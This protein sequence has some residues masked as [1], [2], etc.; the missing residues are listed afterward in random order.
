[1]AT[2]TYQCDKCNQK[3]DL[4]EKVGKLDHVGKCTITKSCGGSLYKLKR[5]VNNIRTNVAFGSTPQTYLKRNI[6]NGYRQTVPSKIWKIEHELGKSVVIIIFGEDG[7]VVNSSQYEINNDGN[8]ATITFTSSINGYAHVLS[9]VNTP[10][11]NFDSERN[12]A[13]FKLSTNHILTFAIPNYIT[14]FDSGAGASS[15]SFNP[16]LNICSA[17]IKIE[18]EVIRP[19]SAPIYCYEDLKEIDSEYVGAWYNWDK[20]L[21]RNRKQY[22]LRYLNLKH[23]R[24]L[25]PNY[26]TESDLVNGTQMKITKISYDGINYFNIPD[27]GLLVLLSNPPYKYSDKVLDKFVDCGEIVG[28]SNELYTFLHEELYTYIDV[29]ETTFPIITKSKH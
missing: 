5:N 11:I 13:T 23:L 8:I 10:I 29:V 26:S 3:I 17:P 9:R 20:I 2:I 6:F 28:T 12:D 4:L 15:T 25:T 27:K 16:P 19:N 22:C 1:M 21:I 14:R 18:V 24:S 7:H